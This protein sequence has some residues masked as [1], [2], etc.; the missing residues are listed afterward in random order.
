MSMYQWTKGQR[1]ELQVIA[2]ECV[3][4]G[5][6]KEFLGPLYAAIYLNVGPLTKRDVEVGQKIW[7]ELQKEQ[8]VD[9]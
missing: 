1:Q 2:D 6:P 4:M 7:R 3:R 5:A 9:T 8:P